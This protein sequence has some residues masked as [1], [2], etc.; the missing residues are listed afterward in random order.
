MDARHHPGMGR[1][2]VGP[3]AEVLILGAVAVTL[4]WMSQAWLIATIALLMTL[5]V[6]VAMVVELWR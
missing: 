3:Y 2:R 5:G 6:A 4:A 1:R